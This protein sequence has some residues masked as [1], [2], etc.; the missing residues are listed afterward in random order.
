M[1][2]AAGQGPLSPKMGNAAV[3]DRVAGRRKA[4]CCD[5]HHIATAEIPL[6]VGPKVARESPSRLERV[7]A[8]GPCS[9]Y[10]R[11]LLSSSWFQLWLVWGLGRNGRRSPTLRIVGA[12]TADPSL[13][14]ITHNGA[15]PYARAADLEIKPAPVVDRGARDGAPEQAQPE[16]AKINP[17]PAHASAAPPAPQVKLASTAERPF[18]EK[19]PGETRQAAEQQPPKQDDRSAREPGQEREVHR[20]QN[21]ANRTQGN[22]AK[23]EKSDRAVQNRNSRHPP[24]CSAQMIFAERKP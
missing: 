1:L 5:G 23:R 3:T 8:S 11:G 16:E 6:S 21:E 12:S 20:A 22:V 17:Q 10:S 2:D 9:R 14:D 18:G 24:R 19:V 13:A 4:P 7:T 15:Q